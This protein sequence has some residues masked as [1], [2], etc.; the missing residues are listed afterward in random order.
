MDGPPPAANYFS[1]VMGMTTI[2]TQ[3]IV[4]FLCVVWG[5]LLKGDLWAQQKDFGSWWEVKLSGSL[6]SGVTL[7]GELEQRMM[8]NSLRFD[9]T[10]LTLI[11]DYNLTS[12]LNVAGGFRTLFLTDRESRFY[13]RYRL[14]ADAKLHHGFSGSDISLRLRFQYGFE[15]ILYI[16]Y[17]SQNNFVSRQRLKFRHAFFGTRLEAFGSL[18]NWI[19]FQDTNGRPFYKIRFYAGTAYKL[20]MHSALS[21]R[22]ILEHEFNTVRPRQAHVLAL[23]YSYTF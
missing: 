2:K 13:S 17:F 7:S 15:D 23:A 11:A 22:Y 8:A 18:E 10:L 3:T 16:G 4:P 20:T 1:L 9:R 5:L 12:Y 19:R 14:H 6:S 21:L